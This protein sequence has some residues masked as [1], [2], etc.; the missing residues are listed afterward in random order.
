MGY[1]NKT[2][3]PIGVNKPGTNTTFLDGKTSNLMPLPQ[4]SSNY[5][6]RT[7]HHKTDLSLEV[8]SVVSFNSEINTILPYAMNQIQFQFSFAQTISGVPGLTILSIGNFDSAPKF[9]GI[10][11]VGGFGSV[12]STSTGVVQ[13]VFT[14]RADIGFALY[15]D[16]YKNGSIIQTISVNT[17]SPISIANADNIYIE[18]RTSD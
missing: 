1:L 12:G 17:F 4:K 3:L 13:F 8:K 11:G 18:T 10:N 6:Q 9:T 5:Y 15:A 14:Y 7:K 16:L 2:I